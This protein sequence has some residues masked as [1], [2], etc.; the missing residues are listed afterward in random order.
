MVYKDSL[1]NKNKDID[2]YFY[3]DSK[4]YQLYTK[5][6]IFTAIEEGKVIATTPENV[7]T[8][9]VE[10]G[11]TFYRICWIEDELIDLN[12]QFSSH[13]ERLHLMKTYKYVIK[14]AELIRKLKQKK[15]SINRISEKNSNQS[16]SL[17][18]PTNKK[19]NEEI[20]Y[21]KKTFEE[22]RKK[23]IQQFK[24]M[25]GGWEYAFIFED[26]YLAYVDI[27]ACFFNN[28]P[29]EKPVKEIRLKKNCKTILAENLIHIYRNCKPH[30]SKFK[31]DLEF[32][33]VVRILEPYNLMLPEKMLDYLRKF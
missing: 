5:D 28:N 23:I 22:Y 30:G 14:A 18:Q 29:Y 10:P 3:D 19:T 12:L 27:L 32:F 16:I 8:P 17:I 11:Y 4:I 33:E 24:T 25:D 20:E 6:D 2:T 31:N 7:P 26:D 13:K 21:D 1:L 9:E 15:Y